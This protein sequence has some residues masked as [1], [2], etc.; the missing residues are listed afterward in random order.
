MDDRT[1]AE[2]YLLDEI[3]RGSD[4]AWSQLVERYQ[5]RLTAFARGRVP[6]GT[7]PEDLVQETFLHFLRGLEAFRAQASIETYLFVI[8]RRRI[9]ELHRGVPAR[10]CSMTVSDDS[11]D[12][13]QPASAGERTAS[14]YAR[15]AEQRDAARGALTTALRSLIHGMHQ[16][17]ELHDMQI[18]ELVFYAQWPNQR[19]AAELKED[20]NHV[21]VLKHRW[22]KQLR[23]RVLQL[24][25][26]RLGD[27]SIPWDSP[28]ILDSLLTE[29]W[30]DERLSCPKRST[31]GGF[32]LHT[33]DDPW[34]EYV[35]FHIHRVGCP[36]CRANLDDLQAQSQQDP[37][38]LRQ[39]IL[40]ST[41]GFFR[42]G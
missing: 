1:E 14:W 17:L 4:E 28:D 34:Q 25:D 33:L 38:P 27:P 22:L 36:F 40:Q 29:I 26:H 13:G 18:V 19:I 41:V 3:R 9:A 32:V 10:V 39:R 11:S 6:R 24:L 42:K 21:A 2:R 8:L 23:D 35:N 7:D 20:A 15:Q 31:V 12:I 37:A 16:K 30:E 5:G